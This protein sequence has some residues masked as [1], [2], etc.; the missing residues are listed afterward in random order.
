MLGWLA[1]L[2]Y[3]PHHLLELLPCDF[4]LCVSLAE[5]AGRRVSL[6]PRPPIIRSRLSVLEPDEEHDHEDREED[7]E[8]LAEEVVAVCREGQED[9]E[10]N[11]QSD[12]QRKEPSQRPVRW[13]GVSCLH[14]QLFSRQ[15]S[16]SIRHLGTGNM[17]GDGLVFVAA[18]QKVY[19][20]KPH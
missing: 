1:T 10:C 14:C 20:I 9:H 7:Y 12:G 16:I 2:T 6:H 15:G 17:A 8:E 3:V 11:H 18:S 13:S 5:D 19:C 4:A